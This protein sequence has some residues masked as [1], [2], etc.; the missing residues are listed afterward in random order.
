M[1]SLALDPLSEPRLNTRP[2]PSLDPFAS[3]DGDQ[4]AVE[5]PVG[6]ITLTAIGDALDTLNFGRAEGRDR[7]SPVLRETA[8]QLE[9][10]F[11]GDLK[12]FDLPLTKAPTP[13]AAAVRQAM[14]DIPFGGTGSYGG[15]AQAYGGSPRSVGNAC[16]H[17]KIA[18]IVPC[19][20][21]LGAGGRIGGFGGSTDPNGPA[22]NRKRWLLAHEGATLL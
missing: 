6:W 18:V 11:E 7:P 19:H 17:N 2:D 9:A 4:L 12:A 10:Y 21:V 8:K 3:S 15:I 20:R 16:R 22:L 14:L 1:T 13:H 5:S